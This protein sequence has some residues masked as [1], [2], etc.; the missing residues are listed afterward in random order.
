MPLKRTRRD[1]SNGNMSNGTTEIR[2]D[3][4]VGSSRG[5]THPGRQG[6]LDRISRKSL[7]TATRG[8]ERQLKNQ[9]HLM[10]P[11]AWG[12]RSVPNRKGAAG[13]NRPKKVKRF[14]LKNVKNF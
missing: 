13:S 3:P 10:P 14:L 1:L 11:G 4:L 2:G 9:K 6:K 12:M 5:V 7:A 8:S